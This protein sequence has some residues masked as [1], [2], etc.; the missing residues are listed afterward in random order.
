MYFLGNCVH[1]LGHCV[2]YLWELVYYLEDCMD[3]LGDCVDYLGDCMFYFLGDCV[4]C[5]LVDCVVHRRLPGG[6]SVLPGR[7]HALLPEDCMYCL[8]YCVY[9]L[10]DCMYCLR[11]LCT[12]WETVCT[13]WETSYTAWETVFTAWE[14]AWTTWETAPLPSHGLDQNPAEDDEAANQQPSDQLNILSW[15]DNPMSGRR[16][17]CGYPW[18][19]D[20]MSNVNKWKVSWG[21]RRQ[22]V[23]MIYFAV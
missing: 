1:Y 3:Y 22:G 14:T 19:M 18:T 5:F 16:I 15:V 23:T 17:S 9:C 8:R 2:Y 20:C 7:L 21:E 12:A 4:V 13:T 6:L 10:R 11:D